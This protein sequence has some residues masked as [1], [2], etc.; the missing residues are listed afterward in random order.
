VVTNP[1]PLTSPVCAWVVSNYLDNSLMLFAPSGQ[2]LGSLGAFGAQTTVAWQSP[3]GNPA[4]TMEQDLAAPELA[5]VLKFATFIHGQSRDFFDELTSSIEGAHTYI[6]PDTGRSDQPYAILM[7]RPLAL[8]RAG[9]RLELAGLPS[10]DTYLASVRATID[11]GGDGTYDWT[12]RDTAGL[13]DVDFPV[14]L[15]D[16]N[17]LE[18]GLVAYLIDDSAAYD[19]IYAS[20]ATRADGTGVRRPAPDT[21]CLKLR[22]NIDPPASRFADPAAQTAALRDA[23]V[24]PI[25]TAVT[26]LMDPRASVHATTGILPVKAIDLPAEIYSRA[27]QSIEVAF[28]THPVLRGSQGLALPVPD[29]SGFIWRW[30]MGV[31]QD[32]AAQPHDEDL[33]A[34]Q[35]GDRAHFSF[36]P[37]VAQDGW[38]KLVPRPADSNS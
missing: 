13:L 19:T 15:G 8:V 26:L 9:L 2:P 38:L 35:I 1:H 34:L 25:R 36:T 30:T 21:L 32:G 10:F 37:Q 24:A 17:H 3:P 22:A 11:A 28:F 20:A 6:L 7:G 31:K 4:R 23:T 16:R 14:R 12:Q 33:L 5:H 29:E 27:L 18:D